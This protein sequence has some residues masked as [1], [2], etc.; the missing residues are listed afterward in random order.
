MATSGGAPHS[1]NAL[2]QRGRPLPK[3]KRTSFQMEKGGALSTKASASAATVPLASSSQ[4]PAS[5]A[6]VPLA[7]STKVSASAG[8]V[9]PAVRLSDGIAILVPATG[10]APGSRRCSIATGPPTARVCGVRPAAGR[11]QPKLK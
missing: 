6:T 4:A 5:A 2:R 10:S 1:S 11:D 7:S 9:P 8:N 3:K